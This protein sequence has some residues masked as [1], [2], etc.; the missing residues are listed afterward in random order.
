MVALSLIFSAIAGGLSSFYLQ[1]IIEFI[2]NKEKNKSCENLEQKSLSEYPV[3]KS[4]SVD[5]DFPDVGLSITEIE[6][7]ENQEQR[8]QRLVSLYP[9]DYKNYK[10][11]YSEREINPSEE[12]LIIKTM[13]LYDANLVKVVD[14]NQYV[15][16]TSNNI[17]F[18]IAN[19]DF[20]F[21]SVYRENDVLYKKSFGFSD[22][23]VY[24]RYS[25]ET[26]MD[27]VDWYTKI[28]NPFEWRRLHENYNRTVYAKKYL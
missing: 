6:I 21:L 27:A 3:K 17:E 22:N 10:N 19:R 8:L 28:T 2:S 12:L 7:N 14:V 23:R 9:S 1:K 18:W 16:K 15:I 20:N 25:F 4:L 13:S 11:T 24:Y 5:P 26:F